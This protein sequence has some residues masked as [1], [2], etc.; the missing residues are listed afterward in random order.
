MEL[1]KKTKHHQMQVSSISLVNTELSS[2]YI[3]PNF[4]NLVIITRFVLQSKATYPRLL[5]SIQDQTIASTI[6]APE[7]IKKAYYE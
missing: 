6:K 2:R 1:Y 3:Y 5:K 4:T 7:Q